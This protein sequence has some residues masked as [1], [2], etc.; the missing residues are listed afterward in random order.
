M[1]RIRNILVIVDPTADE[2]TSLEKAELLA[3]R[4]DARVE[5]YIC[6]TKAARELR[7]RAQRARDPSQ[8]L[9]VNLKPMLEGLAQPMRDKG[10]DVCTDVE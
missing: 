10:I 8:L 5:L 9:D 6:D 2:H 7:L 4:F 1:N 3:K